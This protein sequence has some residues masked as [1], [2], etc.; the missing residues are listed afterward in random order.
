MSS[1]YCAPC[2]RIPMSRFGLA[3]A[4]LLLL[5][6]CSSGGGSNPSTDT[7]PD[8]ALDFYVP[9]LVVDTAPEYHPDE[10][11]IFDLVETVEI[12]PDLPP[13]IPEPDEITQPDEKP[14]I[15]CTKDSD[16]AAAEL[17]LTP[18]QEPLCD[19]HLFICVAGPR[20]PGAVCDDGNACT[21]RTVCTLDGACVGEP[22][23]CDD[24]NICTTDLCF[25][26]SGCAFQPNDN[27]CDDGNSCTDNDRCNNHQCVGQASLECTCATDSD[28]NQFNDTNLCN[29]VVRC[30][31]GTCKVPASSIVTCSSATDTPCRKTLCA[32]DTGE[33]EQIILEDGRPCDDSDACTI[34]DLCKAG[35]CIGSAPRSCD[36]GNVCTN[37]TCDPTD[38]CRNEYSLFPCDDGDSCTQNDFCRFGQCMPGP[39]NSCTNETCFPK[40]SLYCDGSDAWATNL[41]GTTGYNATYSCSGMPM[42]GD[43]FTYSFVAPYDGRASITLTADPTTTFLFLLESK[44]TGCDATNCRTSTNGTLTIDMFEGRSYFLVVDTTTTDSE[45]YSVSVSCVPAH[46]IRCG[47]GLDE[48]ADGQADC[49]DSDCAGTDECPSAYC[50]PVWALSC[51]SKD[52][53]TNY[54]LWSTSLITSYGD[55]NENKGC[56]DNT[57][58]YE[59]PEFAYRFDAP[60]DFNVTVR[61]G[62][63]SAMTDLLILKDNGNGCQPLDCV[64]WGQKKVSFPAQSGERYYFVVDGY[65]G[66]KG[67]FDIEVL[68]TGFVETSC[69]NNEDDDL[70]S[71]TDCDDPDCFGALECVHEC[72][73]ARTIECGHKEAFANFGWGSTLAISQY[74]PSPQCPSYQYTGPEIAYR[75]VAPYDMQVTANLQLETASTDLLVLEGEAC[76]PTACIAYGLSSVTFNAVAGQTYH[77]VVDGFK[78]EAG[79]FLFDLACTAPTEVLCDDGVDNDGDGLVD[80]ADQADCSSSPLCPKC[81][82]TYPIKCGDV[83]E[84]NNGEDGH[85]DNVLEYGCHSAVY[86]GPEYAYAFTAKE[87]EKVSFVVESAGWDLDV[88]VLSDNG[89]GCDPAACL[90]WGTNVATIDAQKNE[91]Y[92]VVVDGYG[93]APELAP[94]TFGTSDFTLRVQCGTTP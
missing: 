89:Y 50:V 36:D 90:T 7:T 2:G 58:A 3:L 59:G 4:S 55:A 32:P 71:F 12:V 73:A 35:V 46:E 6:A 70:D 85:T 17:N 41:E 42:P 84:W 8:S 54:G 68:C 24:D 63:E 19:K 83:E 21:T 34:G 53:A 20:S 45:P 47:D 78:G 16:C 27:V 26:D 79:T 75:F 1:S 38:G 65:Q 64:A 72:L 5:A 10:I 9:D 52:F 30:L 22:V 29:G 25:A 31:F 40:W 18:C 56:L 86:G 44:G 60:G 94:P 49:A 57:Y 14:Q 82:A 15:D 66:A 69:H 33:C 93:Q 87:T 67:S 13:E 37:D 23:H 80:C 74:S 62:N 61:L 11:P 76:L 43:E 92:F 88:M 77:I 81:S 39:L 51:N 91:T 28:C 48:D